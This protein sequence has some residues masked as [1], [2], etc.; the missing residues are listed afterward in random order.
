MSSNKKNKGYFWIGILL[1]VLAGVFFLGKPVQWLPPSVPSFP[2][3]VKPPPPHYAGE[4]VS[5]TAKL[6]ESLNQRLGKLDLLKL[7]D[8]EVS[9]RKVSVQGKSVPAYQETFRLPDHIP[10]A[11]LARELTEAARQVGA[12]AL[13]FEENEDSERQETR[14]E[15][16]FG[17]SGEWVPVEII[18]TRTRR[19]RVCVIIDDGGYRRGVLL[20]RLYSLKVPLTL[21]VIPGLVFSTRI[22]KDA[23]ERGVEILCHLPMEGSEV[24][25]PKA[26]PFFLKKGMPPGQVEAFVEEALE[27]VPGCRGMNNHMGSRAT[28]DKDLMLQV[29][30]VLKARGLFFVDS[31]TAVDSVAAQTAASVHMPYA[32][33]NVFLDNEAEPEAIQKQFQLLLKRAQKKGKAV[34]IGHLH[35]TT[36]DALAPVI[37][38]ARSQG[39]V[40]VY[41]SEVVK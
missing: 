1:L 3:T 18:F 36:L 29:C 20:E 2:P 31:R 37:A 40:F 41:A 11:L 4:P 14:Y 8:R 25:K 32:E 39:F 19:P 16:A 38:E 6:L 5:D 27:S 35:E 15:C 30:S 23:S 26:Y 17:F 21:A 7:L 9:V 28:E 33:R 22:A 12:R 13:R 24:V 10:P 34:G